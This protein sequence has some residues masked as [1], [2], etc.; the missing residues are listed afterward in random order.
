MSPA[1]T[2]IFLSLTFHWPR[3]SNQG[4]SSHFKVLKLI[5]PTEPFFFFFNHLRYPIHWFQDEDMGIFGQEWGTVVPATH[6]NG[7]A[8]R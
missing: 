2:V 7:D 1:S 8:C 3:L 5:T 4:Y 6:M